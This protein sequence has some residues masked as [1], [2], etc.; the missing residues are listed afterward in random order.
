VNLG[1]VSAVQRAGPDRL[2]L[3]LSNAAR[4]ELE[5]ARRQAPRLRERLRL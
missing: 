4:T 1:K 2:R 5:V 3:V